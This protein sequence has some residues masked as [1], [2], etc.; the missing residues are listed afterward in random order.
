MQITHFWDLPDGL[1][2]PWRQDL[3]V[4]LDGLFGAILSAKHCHM[5][6]VLTP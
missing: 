5:G 2:V 6:T 1:C 4:S 3:T